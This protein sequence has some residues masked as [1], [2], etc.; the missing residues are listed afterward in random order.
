MVELLNDKELVG[1]KIEFNI[2]KRFAGVKSVVGAEYY[3]KMMVDFDDLLDVKLNKIKSEVK[4]AKEIK[5]GFKVIMKANFHNRLNLGYQV[6]LMSNIDVL[7]AEYLKWVKSFG[8]SDNFYATLVS[9]LEKYVNSQITDSMPV[10]SYLDLT[11]KEEKK[12][13]SVAKTKQIEV[14]VSKKKEATME[15]KIIDVNF[16]EEKSKEVP[17]N[18]KPNE[19]EIT[20]EQVKEFIVGAKSKFDEVYDV[21]MDKFKVLKFKQW[22]MVAITGN[23]FKMINNTKSSLYSTINELLGLLFEGLETKKDLVYD[24]LIALVEEDLL[25]VDFFTGL[26]TQFDKSEY[27][28]MTGN[29]IKN[30]DKIKNCISN[31]IPIILDELMVDVVDKEQVVE[32]YIAICDLLQSD[33][34]DKDNVIKAITEDIQ[35]SSDNPE[36]DLQ[37]IKTISET[38]EAAQTFQPQNYNTMN[39]QQPIIQQFRPISEPSD[40]ND[41]EGEEGFVNAGK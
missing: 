22:Q 29:L 20:K 18:N 4:F 9:G 36:A 32:I 27:I 12:N 1:T 2:V 13:T 37:I 39:Q 28:I 14:E 5:Q 33:I 3:N 11:K 7:F 6:I 41:Y 10:E 30:F 38:T 25:I 24:S 40:L 17:V 15:N 19:E 35:K 8:G 23:V 34:F 21:A 31:S 16:T 26:Q